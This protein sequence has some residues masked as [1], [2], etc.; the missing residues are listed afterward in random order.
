MLMFCVRVLWLGAALAAGADLLAAEKTPPTPAPG[1][2]ALPAVPGNKL[3]DGAAAAALR[4]FI[5]DLAPRRLHALSVLTVRGGNFGKDVPGRV[6]TM[7]M[8]GNGFG[9]SLDVRRWT[10]TEV[11]VVIPKG[12]PAGRYYVGAADARGQW[13]SGIDQSFEVLPDVRNVAVS[14]EITFRCLVDVVAAPPAIPVVLTPAGGRGA[15]AS[16]SLALA[17]SHP[18]SFGTLVYRYEGRLGLRLGNWTAAADR[19]PRFEIN[20]WD[21]PPSYWLSPECFAHRRVTGSGAPLPTPVRQN[22]QVPLAGAAI[23]TDDTNALAFQATMLI[24]LGSM[25]PPS[26]VC[27]PEGCT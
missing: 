25:P 14:L 17:G 8:G 3:A 15:P 9:A 26:P 20:S 12:V 6:L 7:R 10:P 27:P 13:A 24:D 19:G 2:A 21:V 23:V 16:G 4:P 11:D 18:G 22:R 1:G 5:A